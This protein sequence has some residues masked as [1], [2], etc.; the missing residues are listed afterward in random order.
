MMESM[1]NAAKSWIAKV[2]LGILAASFGVW[3][4]ADVFRG[5]HAGALVTVGS[6]EISAQEFTRSLTRYLQDLQQQTGQAISSEDAR[7]LGIDRS[8]LNNLVQTAAV[9][10]QAKRLKLGVG[11]S[12]IVDETAANPNFQGADGKLDKQTFLSLLQQ[13]GL[14]EQIY[15]ASE[16]RNKLRQAINDAVSADF[17]P[18]QALLEALYRDRNEQRDARYFVIKT[19]D[20]EIPAP[21]D[22]DI[23]KQYEA[24]PAAYTAPEYRTVAVMAVEP[25]DIAKKQ[26]IT[27]EDLKAGYE[28]Y[29]A[30]YYTPEKR[31]ILQ[32]TFPSEAEAKAAKDKIAAGTDFMAVAK[33]RGLTEADATFTDAVKTDF[34]DPAVAEAAFSLAEGTVSD[35]IKGGFATTLLKIVKVTPDHQASLDEVKLKLTERLQLERAADEIDSIYNAVEDARAAQTKFEAIADTAG[36]SF[37]LIGPVDAT[38]RG[39]D[40]KDITFPHSAEVLKAAFES[41]VGVENDAISLDQGYAWYEVREVA[42]SAVKPLAEV[43]DQVVKDIIA[44]KVR[45]VSLDKAK[46]L[47]ER[48]SGGIAMED[49]AKETNATIQTATGLKRNE[50]SADFDA[51]AVKAVFAIPENSFT[52]ALEG[53]GKGAKVIQS[54]AVLLPPFDPKSEEAKQIAGQANQGLGSDGMAAYLAQLQRQAGV[55]INEELWRQIAGTA[56][57]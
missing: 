30:D 39:K 36:I 10:D 16:K 14:T 51:E 29:K 25:A 48:A 17:A 22:D 20:G 15:M 13:N 33:E 43:K 9:D 21:T 8:V 12:L 5:Y 52:Y 44:A 3:G 42:P 40:G 50:T 57:Q 18:P 6:E 23:K 28:K 41:D 38:G 7:K 37:K 1:R 11:D 55:T 19:A 4:I 32:I 34:L 2:L 31:T 27:D 24:N 54:Q 53:D 56:Q 49:L 46:K 35:P 45:E 26:T 47:A